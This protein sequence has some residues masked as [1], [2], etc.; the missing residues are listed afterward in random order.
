MVS[1]WEQYEE[2]CTARTKL[3]CVESRKYYD[4]LRV[5]E[6]LEEK[7]KSLQ[8]DLGKAVG[9]GVGS[10]QSVNLQ[11]KELAGQQTAHL[12]EENKKILQQKK[13]I[14]KERDVLKEE[15]KRLE[16]GINDLLKAAEVHRQKLQKMKQLIGE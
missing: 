11:V 12:V 16:A 5:N 7:V 8:I 9:E 13:E 14:E 3:A 1:L 10:Q 4:L 15:K 2:E 6:K